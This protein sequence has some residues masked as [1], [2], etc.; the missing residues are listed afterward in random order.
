MI[1]SII[2][3]LPAFKNQRFYFHNTK[4]DE[5][6]LAVS[7]PLKMSLLNF[8]D[9]ES[10]S[11]QCNERKNGGHGITF[12]LCHALVKIIIPEHK[13]TSVQKLLIA[14]VCGSNLTNCAY[15][16]NVQN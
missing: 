12:T 4:R 15:E 14:S 1:S 6:E 11:L 7:K 3:K 13:T 16:I 8:N 9:K 5:D 2:V 10:K